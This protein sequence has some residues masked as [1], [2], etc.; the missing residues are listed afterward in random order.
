[1]VRRLW[2]NFWGEDSG[3]DAIAFAR[4][5]PDARTTAA[6]GAVL[7]DPAPDR[8][9]LAILAHRRGG[10]AMT[11]DSER[12]VISAAIWIGQWSRDTAEPTYDRAAIEATLRAKLPRGTDHELTLSEIRRYR[13]GP[14]LELTTHT[15]AAVMTVLAELAR[16]LDGQLHLQA[17]DVDPLGAALRRLV[18]DLGR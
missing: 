8:K 5:M 15:P 18:E 1:V 2:V 13:P 17:R 3:A 12:V 16:S 10:D 9:R 14:H 7:I 11:L 6:G 4:T